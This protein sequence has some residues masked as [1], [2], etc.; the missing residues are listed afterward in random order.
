MVIDGTHVTIVRGDHATLYLTTRYQDVSDSH[1][2]AK[3]YATDLW[4]VI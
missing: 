1:L 3:R 4:K 2:A